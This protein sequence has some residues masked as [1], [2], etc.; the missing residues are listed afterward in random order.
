M[1]DER[2]FRGIHHQQHV[3]SRPLRIEEE[4]GSTRNPGPLDKGPARVTDH[5]YETSPGFRM[6]EFRLDL[7]GGRFEF[8]IQPNSAPGLKNH[9]FRHLVEVHGEGT[10]PRGSTKGGG[11]FGNPL[12]DSLMRRAMKAGRIWSRSS[13]TYTRDSGGH[14]SDSES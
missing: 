7:T 5:E 13:L 8:K 4:A 9:E 14:G 11:Q 1:N 2:F 3:R 12:R 6:V 10:R